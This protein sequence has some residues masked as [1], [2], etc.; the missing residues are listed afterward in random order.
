MDVGI[1]PPT[2]VDKDDFGV[3]PR[4]GSNTD[5]GGK[6]TELRSFEGMGWIRRPALRERCSDMALE[7][8][9]READGLMRPFTD[10]GAT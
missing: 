3:V 1:V 9:A 4:R 7:V 8:L 10:P 5:V 6:G 2:G